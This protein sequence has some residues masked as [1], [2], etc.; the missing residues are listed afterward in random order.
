MKS[1]DKK[2]TKRKSSSGR[3]HAAPSKRLRLEYVDPA[4]LSDNPQ[5]WRS[6]PESQMAALEALLE[7]PEI[8]WAGVILFNE[9]TGRLIDGH[10][11]KQKWIEKHPG[12]DA[13]VLIGSW[14]E[15]AEQKILLTF[16]PI[17]SMAEANARQLEQLK[18]AVTLDD[19]RL[20]GLRDSLAITLKAAMA[21]ISMQANDTPTASSGGS[22]GGRRGGISDTYKIIITCRDEDHQTELLDRFEKEKI[23]ARALVS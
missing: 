23:E 22:S 4:S 13:P 7:D 20:A 18:G 2:G 8:G 17:S 10:A 19:D 6:H 11:R 1:N 14:S 21:S 9:R 15:E 12:E 5:N 16:D 3:A